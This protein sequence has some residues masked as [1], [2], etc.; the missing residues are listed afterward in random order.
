M[1]YE[2]KKMDLLLDIL[3]R[4]GL[5]S[6]KIAQI[7][8]WADSDEHTLK[9]VFDRPNSTQQADD[10]DSIFLSKH[11]LHS[12]IQM[13]VR[14]IERDASVVAEF[15]K[16][17]HKSKSDTRTKV[18]KKPRKAEIAI[19]KAAKKYAKKIKIIST[20]IVRLS[21]FE[22]NLRF[23][24]IKDKSLDR[25]LIIP[26]DRAHKMRRPAKRLLKEAKRFFVTSEMIRLT[27]YINELSKK[28]SHEIELASVL[29]KQDLKGWL[30]SIFE[31]KRRGILIMRSDNPSAIA[32]CR[33]LADEI[34]KELDRKGIKTRGA[35]VAEKRIDN[36][37]VA[38]INIVEELIDSENVL[39]KE[40]ERFR[41]VRRG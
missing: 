39:A 20:C 2:T 12:Q 8:T 40:Y 21:D 19:N 41:L 37:P 30:E 33:E 22:S 31:E 25:A 35:S 13:D 14:V 23:D 17:G 32:L 7:L 5:S 27:P 38:K 18:K 1:G 11:E 16:H 29:P 3:K 28:Y 9:I 4:N 34:A 26:E 10:V 24:R 15:I 6:K 36:K